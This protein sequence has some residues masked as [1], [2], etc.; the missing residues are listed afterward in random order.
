MRGS[1]MM[2]NVNESTLVVI[3]DINSDTTWSAAFIFFIYI[4]IKARLMKITFI[5][6]HTDT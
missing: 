4:P 3:P 2:T 5:F 1:N 6:Y